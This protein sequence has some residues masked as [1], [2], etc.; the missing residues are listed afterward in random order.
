MKRL[1]KWALATAACISGAS[2]TPPPTSAQDFPETRQK[3]NRLA[4]IYEAKTTEDVISIYF[5]GGLAGSNIAEV[6]ENLYSTVNDLPTRRY[7]IQQNESVC[8]VLSD[9]RYPSPCTPYLPLIER[10]S[11]IKNANLVW[12]GQEVV[13]PDVEL[14]VFRSSRPVANLDE[15]LLENL[16][17]NWGHLNI[18]ITTSKRDNRTRIEFD[19]FELRIKAPNVEARDGL[20]TNF[21][22]LDIPDTF[23]ETAGIGNNDG[24]T[25]QL[26]EASVRQTCDNGELQSNPIDYS[27]YTGSVISDLDLA[28]VD[29]IEPQSKPRLFV[30]DVKLLSAPNLIDNVANRHVSSDTSWTCQWRDWSPQFHATHLAGIVASRTNGNGFIGI[31]PTTQ[32]IARPYRVFTP[33]SGN[34]SVIDVESFKKYITL[35]TLA[36]E[37]SLDLPIFLMASSYRTP[38]EYG[39][40]AIETPEERFRKPN[41]AIERFIKDEEPLLIVAAG[42]GIGDG[43]IDIRPNTLLAPQNLGD[44][45]NVISV[46][47]CI[48]CAGA[49]PSIDPVSNFSGDGMVHVAAPGGEKIPGWVN[50]EGI[51]ASRGTSQAAAFTAGVAARML[52]RYPNAYRTSE[53]VKQR[54]QITS[55]PMV[56]QNGD[57]VPSA[58]KIAT[59]IVDPRL[60]VLDPGV[61]W[62]KNMSGWNRINVSKWTKPTAAFVDAA[63][64]KDYV[65]LSRVRRVV[66]HPGGQFT[67]Y[68]SARAGSQGSRGAIEREHFFQI[69]GD[70]DAALTLCDGSA[71]K[72]RD[73]LDFLPRSGGVQ[74]AD[75]DISP[76]Q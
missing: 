31:E 67:L 9:A 53:R 19:T 16:I 76:C 71:I 28:S 69:D 39:D 26:D 25:Y 58:A 17:E 6:L 73:V 57:I 20:V 14:K 3:Q 64:N 4:E 47:S 38:Q 1:G 8:K 45:P 65:D 66:Q 21:L 60:A 23:I 13:F 46:A 63:G 7:A 62:H 50:P 15:A 51:S 22:A 34:D 41:W 48:D 43:P 2:L 18:E 49:R 72:L 11:S 74:S 24:K 37:A 70:E 40:D 36:N 52:A 75:L 61:D 32:V 30:L 12:V 29:I 5:R 33:Q 35:F 68:L 27:V 44:L 42:Q 55:R 10:L 54:I 59:G 56:D